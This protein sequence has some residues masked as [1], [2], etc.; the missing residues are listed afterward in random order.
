MTTSTK[1]T[2]KKTTTKPAAKKTTATKPA[3]KKT[4]TTKSA[5]KNT[6]T[7]KSVANKATATKSVAKKTT[8]AKPIA[9]KTTTKPATKKTVTTKSDIKSTEIS[10]TGNKKIGT[11]M[12]EFN[13]QF[14]YISIGIFYSYARQQV[15]KGEPIVLIDGD[16]TLASVRRADSG[17]DISISGN[18]KIKTL[19]K[20][21][22]TVFGL[23]AQ[24][25]FTTK[26][27][28]RHYTSGSLDEMTL[29]AFNKKCEADGCKKGV[30][31]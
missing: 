31:K 7:T 29:S 26:E 15:A 20:E 21:F 9:K 19:E 10:V 25:W 14:P 8:A 16:K 28:H 1:N 12:K 18:K 22:D 5:A 2:S 6:S 30:W 13:K 3:V 11:L 27:G 23:Y 4:T 17:G 24:V